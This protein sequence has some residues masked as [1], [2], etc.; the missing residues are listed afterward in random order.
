PARPVI[1]PGLAGANSLDQSAP[2]AGIDPNK[3][4]PAVVDDATNKINAAVSLGVLSRAQADKIIAMLPSLVSDVVNHAFG[5]IGAGFGP[6]SKLPMSLGS[7]GN[8]ASLG[9]FAKLGKLPHLG[10]L[11]NIGDMDDL[12]GM[13]KLHGIGDFK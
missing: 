9:N 10:D 8:L 6:G 2:A 11:A 1:K 4:I 5:D 3:T 13:S 12:P 7:L